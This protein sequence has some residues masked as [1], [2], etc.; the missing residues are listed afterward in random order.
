MT[1]FGVARANG[2][3]DTATS[4]VPVPATR[5]WANRV[6]SR[7]SAPCK[8][9]PVRP[10]SWGS[11]TLGWSGE[12]D[13]AVTLFCLNAVRRDLVGAVVDTKAAWL[14]SSAAGVLGT[15]ARVTITRTAGNYSLIAKHY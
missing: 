13:G 12:A 6:R 9:A 5:S 10:P 4:T 8:T 3:C 11:A 2:T 1:P 7:L 15:K 14:E